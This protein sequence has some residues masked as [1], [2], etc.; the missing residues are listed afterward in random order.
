MIPLL[1]LI[2]VGIHEAVAVTHSL[3]YF[4]TSSSGIHNFPEY[5]SVG[6]IDDVQISHCDSFTKTSTAKQEWMNSVTDEYPLYWQEETT[7]CMKNQLDF[8]MNIQITK[9]RFNQTNGVHVFQ[10]MYGCEWD[11]ETEEVKGFEQFGYNGEDFIAF[12]LETESWIAA[13]QQ[14]F[15]TKQKWDHLK[16][17]REYEKHYFTME[18]VNWLRKYLNC[19]RNS[20]VKTV[21]PSVSLLQ[22]SSSS[23][24]SCHA[25]GF[26]PNRAELLWKKDGEEIHEGVEKGQILP[27]NDG[28]FQM[29][30]DLQ[31]PSGEEMQRYECVFQL[32]GV[33]DQITKLEK[34]KI[35]TNKESLMMVIVGVVVTAVILVVL[36]VSAFILYKKKNAKR[37]PSPVENKEVQQQMLPEQKA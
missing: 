14:A 8:K 19:G 11:D 21:S 22:K 29:S 35:R 30:V 34:T 10:R 37:P 26:Y 2:L 28:T 4:Y 6:V 18:C 31:L 33:K 13:K 1:C 7:T 15:T 32:S 3:Q 27:N 12:D 20:L 16:H 36:A 24:I 17:I 9:E 25:T 23:P 5:V